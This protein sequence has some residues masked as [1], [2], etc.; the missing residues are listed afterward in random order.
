LKTPATLNKIPHSLRTV[1]LI[2]LAS[3]LLI[4]ALGYVTT[5]VSQGP[6]PPLSILLNQ[7]YQWDSVHYLDIAKNWY[8][9]QGPQ[10]NNLVFFPLY[11]L[12]IR[13]IT[14]NTAYINL[15]A[16]AISNISSVIAG[17]Y[18]Y[19]LAKLDYDDNAAVKAVLYMFVFPT[20][21]FMSMMYT[22]GLF[23]ALAIAA[24]YYARAGKWWVAGLLSMFATLT[25]LSGL[26]LLPALLVEYLHQKKWNLKKIE[27]NLLWIFLAMAGFLMYLGLNFQ[28][29]GNLFTF[30]DLERIY[31][32]QSV[33][34]LLGL[35]RAITSTFSRGFPVGLLDFAQLLFAGVGLSAVAIGFKFRLRPSYTAYTLLTW[36]LIVSTS[37]WNSIP[38]YVLTM[39]PMFILMGFA[40]SSRKAQ[41]AIAALSLAVMCAFT[42]LFSFGNFVF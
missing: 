6:A 40:I 26:I 10:L 8:V 12:L 9:N 24:F 14:V 27:L 1:I 17:L 41:Y 4:F 34:P 37:F 5:Y 22:E 35:E 2:I 42:V 19:K 36:I 7:F 3:K 32:Y 38:R 23:L 28:V 25:R 39:F 31:W 29:T 20:A 33:N 30:M 13:L 18:L 21:F 16:L 15:S 11:P